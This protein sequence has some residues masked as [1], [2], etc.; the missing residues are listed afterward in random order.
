MLPLLQCEI[1]LFEWIVPE[2]EEAIATMDLEPFRA[3]ADEMAE[4]HLGTALSAVAMER[5]II[6]AAVTAERKAIM[7]DAERLIDEVTDRTFQ[8]V[9]TQIGNQIGALIPLALAALV[10]P[11]VL[12]FVAAA[13][14][15]KRRGA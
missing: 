5:E 7:A 1:L 6:L 15:L 8:R 10:G 12:G 14:L 2:V 4:E 13:V 9:E 11:F 3:I